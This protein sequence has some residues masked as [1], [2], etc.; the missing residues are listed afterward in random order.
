[1]LKNYI[2]S[3]YHSEIV[4][5]NFENCYFHSFSAMQSNGLRDCLECFDETTKETPESIIEKWNYTTKKNQLLSEIISERLSE[6][7]KYNYSS[8]FWNYL[9]SLNLLKYITILHNF[10]SK[11]EEKFKKEQFLVNETNLNEI[12]DFCNF[13]QVNEFLNVQS[14]GKEFLLTIYYI[15]FFKKNDLKF[16]YNSSCSKVNNLSLRQSL[17]NAKKSI[18]RAITNHSKIK[19][20]ILGAYFDR[21]DFEYSQ[22]K[23]WI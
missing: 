22:K 15:L 11:L 13:E 9:Y 20:G 3:D 12:K 21:D 1:M 14:E 16:A 7:Y 2:V 18:L 6:F 5:N 10:F 8:K 4:K 19:V 23:I 17:V